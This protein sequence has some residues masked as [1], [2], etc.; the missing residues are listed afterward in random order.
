MR[1]LQSIQVL[2]GVAACA[3]VFHHAYRQVDP[4]TFARVGAAGVDLFFVISGFIMATIGPGRSPT[5]F[6][7][8]RIWRI[9]PLWLV[10]VSPWFIWGRQD[11][12]TTLASLTLWPIWN[13]NFTAPALLLGWSLCFEMLFYFAFAAALA[14]RAFVPL[15]VFLVC[16]FVGAPNDLTAYL[17]SPLIFEFL[18]GV[19]IAQIN[20]TKH[21]ALFIAVGILWLCLA[22]VVYYQELFGAGGFARVFSWGVPAALI[23][24]GALSFEDRLSSRLARPFVL[25]GNAS[26]SIYLFHL[27]P[28]RVITYHWTAAL[29]GGILTGLAAW[30]LI[31]RPLL[32]LRR[33]GTLRW[34]RHIPSLKRTAQ[35]PS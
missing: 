14:T 21:G 25:L 15:S 3:V 10:A 8:D 11:V 6:M 32:G 34:G 13:G 27:I 30:W 29:A 23:V 16:L 9:F 22:P 35:R 24:F 7:S 2:R 26:Y 18:A 1:K 28:V 33:A 4:D 19:L 31:E 20:P 17:G 5:R 12:P